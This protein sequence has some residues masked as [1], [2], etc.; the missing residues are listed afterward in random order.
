M[1]LVLEPIQA[2]HA[3]EVQILASD[4]RIGQTSNLPSPYPED[5]AKT[6]IQETVWLRERGREY[7]FAIVDDETLIGVCGL[8]GVDREEGFAEVGYWIGRPFWGHG[9]ATKCT[10]R[11]LTYAFVDLSLS[12]LTSRCILKNRPSFR[13]LEKC[14]F[15]LAAV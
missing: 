15:H 14:G 9:Y 3:P 5:G 2:E 6:W 13:V 1:S 10:R 7:A 12:L 11:L 8:K 4:P